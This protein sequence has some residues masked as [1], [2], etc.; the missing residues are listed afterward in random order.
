MKQSKEWIG[1][2]LHYY[3]SEYLERLTFLGAKVY[4]KSGQ[5]RSLF[6]FD[7]VVSK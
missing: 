1:A 3:R 4:E 6:G 7:W 5:C 2:G